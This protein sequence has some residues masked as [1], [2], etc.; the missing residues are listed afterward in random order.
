MSITETFYFDKEGNVEK[1]SLFKALF[2]AIIVSLVTLLSFGIGRL[3]ATPREG[4]NITFDQEMLKEAG[5][6]PAQT[7][8]RDSVVASS[9]GVR[10]YYSH[11]KNNISEKNRVSFTTA[12]L[13][14]DAGYTLATN[15]KPK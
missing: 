9:Q 1:K 2:V 14:E 10:Y 12:S 4:V 3:T 8:S 7:V 15:C 6:V 13:A 11:C 5:G